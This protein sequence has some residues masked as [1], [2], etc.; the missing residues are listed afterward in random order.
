MPRR[1]E[2]TVLHTRLMP[3]FGLQNITSRRDLNN[4]PTFVAAES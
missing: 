2:Q 3:A 1:Y 4:D